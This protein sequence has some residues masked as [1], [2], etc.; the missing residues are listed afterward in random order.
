MAVIS[1]APTPDTGETVTVV[2]A[3]HNGPGAL[4]TKC[5]QALLDVYIAPKPDVHGS[6]FYVK[7][8]AVVRELVDH[9]SLLKGESNDF[10]RD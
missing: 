3:D 7:T 10:F 1:W 8:V 9:F 4:Q 5:L 6:S 2:I